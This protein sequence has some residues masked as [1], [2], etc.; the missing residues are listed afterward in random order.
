MQSSIDP[1]KSLPICWLTS[2][3]RAEH[4]YLFIEYVE[5]SWFSFA[6]VSATK[7]L[8]RVDFWPPDVKVI[9]FDPS[10]TEKLSELT[11]N[12]VGYALTQSQA[13]KLVDLAW[14]A[15]MTP[16][17]FNYYSGDTSPEANVHN[18]TSFILSLLSQVGVEV[19]STTLHSILRIAS[20][21]SYTTGGWVNYFASLM[22]G[23]PD[24]VIGARVA[25]VGGA[26]TVGCAASGKAS[27]SKASDLP[28]KSPDNTGDGCVFM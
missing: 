6:G 15:K 17:G 22:R 28:D 26:V 13:T 19:E 7:H 14:G 18:C 9:N 12:K 3:S 11:A 21:A 20:P 4:T 1:K 5:E 25:A 24:G 10:N 8:I 27:D 16:P 23:A 2:K